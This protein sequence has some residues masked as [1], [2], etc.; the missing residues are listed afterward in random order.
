[1]TTEPLCLSCGYFV[2]TIG[3]QCDE[4][5]SGHPERGLEA[6]VI[7][8]AIGWRRSLTGLAPHRPAAAALVD[9]VDRLLESE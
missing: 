2:A 1:M 9:A 3:D 6:A 7:A 5:R 4:C 8:S